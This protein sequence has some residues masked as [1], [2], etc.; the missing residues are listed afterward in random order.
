MTPERF[1]Q[2]THLSAAYEW[3]ETYHFS[4]GQ[5]QH[6]Y[7]YHHIDQRTEMPAACVE[8]KSTGQQDNTDVYAEFTTTHT[9]G[10]AEGCCDLDDPDH[11]F[12]YR[13]ERRYGE[14]PQCSQYAA[15]GRSQYEAPRVHYS[16][17]ETVYQSEILP[18][19]EDHARYVP[20]GYV[21]FL[22]SR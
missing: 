6:G 4:Q 18:E 7:N 10:H 2:S 12:Q 3:T 5:T 16:D 13:R 9:G 14:E 21:Q 22:L 17:Q 11:R 8:T 15:D 20:E 19:R 1:P